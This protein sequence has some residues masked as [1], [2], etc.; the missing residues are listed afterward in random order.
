MVTA[1]HIVALIS[2]LVVASVSAR[3]LAGGGR[4]VPR[5]TG[6]VAVGGIIAHGTGLGYYTLEFGELPLV[7]LTPSLSVLAFLIGLSLI[8]LA[9]PG[10]ARA[11]GVVIAPI[12]AL[13]LGLALL[14]GIHPQ[15]ELTTFEGL[16]LYFHTSLVLLGL[17]GLALAFAAGLTYLLQFR[18]LKGKRL[19]RIFRFFPSLEVLDRVGWWALVIGLPALTLGL[20]VGWAWAVRF[21]ATWAIGEPKLIVGG[22]SWIVGATALLL[23]AGAM[24][25]RRC[26]LAS[27][28][29]FVA[30]VVSYLLLRVTE[31]AGTHGGVFL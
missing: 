17:S 31:V 11:L 16:W 12:V 18:E 4:E 8:L 23:R 5:A 15:G 25:R 19:G 9:W 10:E 28:V 1:L 24:G 29:G 21:K 2:Y 20:G 6:L 27:V 14:L 7:G 13:L 26:A 30:I 3:S 22:L